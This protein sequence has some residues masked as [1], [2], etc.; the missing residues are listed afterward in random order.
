MLVKR[1]T[2]HG[3][4]FLFYSLLIPKIKLY[5]KEEP[6]EFFLLTAIR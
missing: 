2:H 1:L 3:K 6:W 5:Y 4:L